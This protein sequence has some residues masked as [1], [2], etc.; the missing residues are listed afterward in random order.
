MLIYGYIYESDSIGVSKRRAYGYTRT[1]LEKIG[2]IL[3]RGAVY[4]YYVAYYVY[5][6]LSAE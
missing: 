3:D 6:A 2:R 4:P 1:L 5:A